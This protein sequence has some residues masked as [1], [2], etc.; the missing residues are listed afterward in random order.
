M[1]KDAVVIVTGGNG[2]LGGTIVRKIKDEGGIPVI[3]DL[4]TDNGYAVDITDYEAVEKAVKGVSE[5]YGRI[6]GLVN[7][8]GGSARGQSRPFVEQEIG[9]IRHI[10]EMNLFGTFYCTRAVVP[11]MY[12]QNSGAIVNISSAVAL[13]GIRKFSDYGAAKGGVIAAT[14]SWAM[15]FGE[16]NIRVNCVCPGKVQR[17]EQMP[18]DPAAFARRYCFLNRICTAEDIAQMVEYLLDDAKSGFITGQNYVVDGG[19][20]LGLK[21]DNING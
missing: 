3:F 14:K 21:G 8:A 19:R 16:H 6:D 13:G 20:S 11:Y 7:C 9:V 1:K 4:H 12:R 17:P 5:Q 2:Y 15:E 10:L 18:S